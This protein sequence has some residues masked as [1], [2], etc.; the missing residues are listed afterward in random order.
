MGFHYYLGVGPNTMV[1]IPKVGNAHNQCFVP[2]F[3]RILRSCQF[4]II[5]WDWQGEESELYH[6]P[7]SPLS[8]PPPPPPSRAS[9]WEIWAAR[10]ALPVLR[11]G[12]CKPPPH[13]PRSGNATAATHSYQLKALGSSGNALLLLRVR[14]CKL[15]PSGVAKPLP[16]P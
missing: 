4:P 1:P 9:S 5:C 7:P 2:D 15:L 13:P 10:A 14:A 12:A 11:V 16:P 3:E 6:F 8:D